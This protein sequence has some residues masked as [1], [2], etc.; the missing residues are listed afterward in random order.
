MWYI[1]LASLSLPYIINSRRDP[2]ERRMHTFNEWIT[3]LV[4]HSFIMFNM[5]SVED[6]FFIGY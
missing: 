6:N 1:S 4:A 3:L 5:V 2:G